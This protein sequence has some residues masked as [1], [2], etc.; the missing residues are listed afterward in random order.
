MKRK[1]PGQTVGDLLFVYEFK[2][3]FHAAV[4]NRAK[5]VECHGADGFVMFEPVKQAAA[6]V[7]IL[8]EFIGCDALFFHGAVKRRVGNHEPTSCNNHKIYSDS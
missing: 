3:I 6:D 5:V 4:E 8:D 2:H 7:V 1:F